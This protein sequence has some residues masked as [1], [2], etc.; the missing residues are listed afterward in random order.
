VARA[1]RLICAGI[2]GILFHILA[3]IEQ[4]ELY[5]YSNGMH[6]DIYSKRPNISNPKISSK[7]I[8]CALHMTTSE[9]KTKGQKYLM[10]VLLLGIAGL[11]NAKRILLTS[12]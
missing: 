5:S 12:S 4:R 11:Y 3:T 10:Q 2:D 8:F 1:P 7:F 6:S 9:E